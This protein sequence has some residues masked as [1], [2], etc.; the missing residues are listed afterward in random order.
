[1]TH[2]SSP[3][4]IRDFAIRSFVDDLP[5]IRVVKFLPDGALVGCEEYPPHHFGGTVPNTGDSIG[6]IWGDADYEMQTVQ[7]RYFLNEWKGRGPYWVIVVRDA[8][9]S[10]QSDAICRQGMLMTDLEQAIE[11]QKPR[12]EVAARIRQL[13]GLPTPGVRKFK[14]SDRPPD[15]LDD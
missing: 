13:D 1:M 14:P 15:E 3:P 8:D 4:M 12:R 10:P 5:K 9:P 2:D 6:M 7:R 11:E